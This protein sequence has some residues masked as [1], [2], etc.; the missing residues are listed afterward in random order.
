MNTKTACSIRAWFGL[1]AMASLVACASGAQSGASNAGQQ[2]AAGLAGPASAGTAG[3]GQTPD[4][5]TPMDREAMCT[6]YHSLQNA[7]TPQQRQAIMDQHM[8]GMT[9]EAREHHLDMM[10]QQ[11][12][13][14][15]TR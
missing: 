8:Q 13:H 4:A 15:P 10:R 2:S 5:L 3:A 1:C 9:R 14:F 11:C 12:S 6:T 7:Q